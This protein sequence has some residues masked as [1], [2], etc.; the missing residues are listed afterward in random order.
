M[1]AQNDQVDFGSFFVSDLAPVSNAAKRRQTR[2]L[3]FIDAEKNHIEAQLNAAKDEEQIAAAAKKLLHGPALKAER[4]NANRSLKTCEASIS[5]LELHQHYLSSLLKAAYAATRRSGKNDTAGMDALVAGQLRRIVE[6]VPLDAFPTSFLAK[7]ASKVSV[8]ASMQVLDQLL[9]IVE[10]RVQFSSS[11]EGIASSSSNVNAS[12]SR[13]FLYLMQG[14]SQAGKPD[15]VHA[16][17]DVL[18]RRSLPT[19]VFHYQLE[20]IALFRD[21]ILHAVNKEQ[22]D[23]ERWSQQV[24]TDILQIKAFMDADDVPIDD[25]F[26]ASV[27]FGL[28]APLRLPLSTYASTAQA[29]QSLQLVRTVFGQIASSIKGTAIREMPRTL[30]ALISAEIDALEPSSETRSDVV[31]AAIDRSEALLSQLEAHFTPSV[32]GPAAAVPASKSLSEYQLSY[33]FLRLRLSSKLGDMPAALTQLRQILSLQPSTEPE[34]TALNKELVLKQRSSVIYLFS[35]SMQ[36]R[37]QITAQDAAYEVLKIAFSS[38]WFDRVWSGH[39]VPSNPAPEHDAKASDGEAT[40]VRLWKRWMWGWSSDVLNEGRLPDVL[41]EEEEKKMDRYETFAGRYEWQT[42]K[43]GLILLNE[44]LDQFEARQLPP[45]SNTAASAANHISRT[46]SRFNTLFTDCS[47][48]NFIVKATLRGRHT[49][50]DPSMSISVDRRLSLLI[51]TLSRT[52]CP[53]RTWESIESF[54]LH[55]LALIDRTIL[56]TDS[57][58][59]AMN[60]IDLHKRQ[61]L[62]RIKEIH[63]AL[64]NAHQ[65]QKTETEVERGEGEGYPPETGSIFVL[66]QMLQQRAARRNPSV[67]QDRPLLTHDVDK[68]RN[69]FLFPSFLQ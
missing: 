34:T 63:Q 45:A 26:L 65:E 20:V 33:R 41:E 12:L 58:R 23:F 8:K 66:R 44:T 69:S 50:N 18:R 30:L 1:K 42:L 11:V 68:E 54:M 7:F 15:R 51:R 2:F 27:V 4:R 43:R 37:T 40:V 38:E 57:I 9:S 61:A 47:V 59:S 17:F 53:A 52:R 62:L 60:Q 49:P 24:Q 10:Q 56:P 22:A 39:V 13:A 5:A 29:M 46:S 35:A 28:S 14:F 3:N 55:H 19:T 67:A 6:L 25:T 48:L 21:P 31:A 36:Q 64:H 32:A 16:C